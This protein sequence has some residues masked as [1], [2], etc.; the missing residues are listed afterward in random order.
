MIQGDPWLLPYSEYW[1]VGL[2]FWLFLRHVF[3]L[4]VLVWS[5]SCFPADSSEVSSQTRSVNSDVCHLFLLRVLRG[6]Y[7]AGHNWRT[8]H[9]ER[10]G[11]GEW[12]HILELCSEKYAIGRFIEY[13][14]LIAHIYSNTN[15]FAIG[16]VHK[17]ENGA[18]KTNSYITIKYGYISACFVLEIRGLPQECFIPILVRKN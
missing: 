8:L 11:T 16:N 1:V 5:D 7:Y 4:L 12:R 10:P 3:L 13:P 15:I 9:R 17:R 18:E 6:G 2:S 14:N